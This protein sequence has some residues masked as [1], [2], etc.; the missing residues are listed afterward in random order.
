MAQITLF[1]PPKDNAFIPR[2]VATNKGNIKISGRVTGAAYT[3]LKLNVYKNHVL[4]NSYQSSFNFNQ[5]LTD[6]THNINLGAGKYI[7]TLEFILSGSATYTKII[8]GIMVGDV[9]LIQGQSNAVACNYVNN[10]IN[11]SAAYN[12]TFIRSFGNSYP[13]S[14]YVI[15]DTNWYK[16]DAENPYLQGS[17]GQ[18]PLVLA[19]TLLDSFDIP[20]CVI[21]G[22]VGGTYI[23]QHTSTPGN[24]ADLNSIYGRLLYR[25]QKAGLENN[26]R[27]ILYF[28]GESDGANAN[29]H[30]SLFRLLY[31]DWNRD[32][33]G[34]KK[35][36]VVQVRGKGCGNPSIVLRNYQRNFEFALSKCKVIS[37]NG[38]NNHDGCHYG[39]SNGYELLGKQLA[40]LV[41]RDLYG[42]LRT[43]NIDPPN[44]KNCYYSNAAQD[45]ITLNM[46]NP[47]DIV[48]ADNLF[49]KI[50]K[51]EGDN[52]VSISSGFI[53]N[54]KVVL[55][56][57]K[58]SCKITGL[59]YDSDIGT[60]PWVKNSTGA[61]LISFYNS[62][63][64]T[65]QIQSFYSGCKKT[66]IT[67]GED[68]ISGCKYLWKR[69]V[70]KQSYTSAK[71]KI[72]GDTTEQF[73]LIITYGATACKQKDTL[74]VYLSP[75]PVTIP[76]LGNDAMVCWQDTL[77]FQPK[78]L[79]FNQ[80]K[81]TSSKGNSD[82]LFYYKT[83]SSEK[84]VLTATSNNQCIYKDSVDITRSKPLIIL[85]KN[86]Y[87]CALK[88]TLISVLDTFK[89][90]SWNK[91]QGT[92]QFRS[93]E[94]KII[95]EV[96]NKYGCKASDT[97]LIRA[98]LPLEK[99]FK[100][101]AV[102]AN[103][104]RIIARPLS[105]KS[106]HSNQK[107]LGNQIIINPNTFSELLYP[108]VLIDT[109]NCSN[110]DTIS[111]TAL[112]IP[113]LNLG[114]DTGFCTG[115]SV[116]ID[117]PFNMKTYFWNNSQISITSI[118]INK[119]D[120]YVAQVIADNNC[121]VNDTITIAEYAIP[122]L[123]N[124]YDTTFCKGQVW[125]P[126]L[127][128]TIQYTVNNLPIIQGFTITEAGYYPIKAISQQACSTQ[129]TITVGTTDCQNSTLNS[130]RDLDIQFF[131]N[132]VLGT[133]TI[134]AKLDHPTE[135]KLVSFDGKLI[136]LYQ[137][138][139]GS[140]QVDL[141]AIPSGTYF[142]ILKG[143][144]WSIVK[145]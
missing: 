129:K 72:K 57:S 45:E 125:V 80:F 64:L 144:A 132:P 140:N 104:L 96:E 20:I 128:N 56:L 11:Y 34:F 1:N 133:L 81:W 9:Y 51:I 67:M 134:T 61:G 98:I 29:V 46:Q 75:D 117:L 40:A 78:T 114:R 19:K 115:T 32:Y 107:I 83:F 142:L 137:L 28:Q 27:G 58:S 24:A 76:E 121:S 92:H 30:D 59:T 3:A 122:T 77:T 48:Y 21:N 105:V 90:Y 69:P 23:T 110:T 31:N 82:Y 37:S 143:Q 16:P 118:K 79:G 108:V 8:D 52:T 109:N 88:D 14:G 136:A 123:S 102:C 116:T 135:A 55:K 6:F 89:K 47:S 54:N 68:S 60:Q 10:A 91:V 139:N 53:R 35:L 4:L 25:V 100:N 2:N 127:D 138:N 112:P 94:G 50:F 18:W 38:L 99:Q 70:T 85:P 5:N 97:S 119:P 17:I 42:S 124:F 84:I 131:P 126:I 7:Y 63:I 130:V 87:V 86:I 62:P 71:I 93:G 26:I 41:S 13:Y 12:D 15:G 120:T 39:F 74:L 111:T 95:L 44:V 65:N 141:S 101:T 103:E 33:K 43:H 36:Y 73:S 22:A 66:L 106:W 113:V 49:Q 145:I